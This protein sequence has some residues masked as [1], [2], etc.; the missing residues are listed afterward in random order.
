MMA[1]GSAVLVATATP[2]FW[3]IPV[4]AAIAGN[5]FLAWF[6]LYTMDKRWAPWVPGIVWCAVM[7]A[8]VAPTS[9]GDLIANSGTGLAT[10]AAGTLTF[11]VMASR[12]TKPRPPRPQALPSA[13]T[14]DPASDLDVHAA[15]APASDIDAHAEPRP[16]PSPRP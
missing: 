1:A 5:A 7:L 4:A 12:A 8:A 16:G 13:P 14:P 9:E 6:A 10:F 15:P 11:F 3:A 2:R